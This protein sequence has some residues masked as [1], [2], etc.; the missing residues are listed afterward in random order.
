MLSSEDVAKSSTMIFHGEENSVP[1][2]E[3]LVKDSFRCSTRDEVGR[4]CRYEI[5]A[6]AIVA[7]ESH[8]YCVS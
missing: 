6:L 1:L 2:S 5:H 4:I 8:F 3:I 7:T